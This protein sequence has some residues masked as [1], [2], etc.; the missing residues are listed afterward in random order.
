MMT[1]GSSR[2][3]FAFPRLSFA[4]RRKTMQI[5][6]PLWG[7]LR[8]KLPGCVREGDNFS[9][10]PVRIYT[11][12]E[13]HQKRDGEGVKRRTAVAAG[14]G[15]T[16][17][18]C[19][20]CEPESATLPILHAG[21]G[22]SISHCYAARCWIGGSRHPRT[23]D[24]KRYPFSFYYLPSSSAHRASDIRIMLALAPTRRRD[25]AG[26]RLG[27]KLG[28]TPASRIVID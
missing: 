21:V 28:D 20:I 2:L 9:V 18:G 3:S 22:P 13:P 16:A 10:A 27:R 1:L 7:T 11:H 6:T 25:P 4:A 12:R 24:F 17:E 8:C 19:V 14:C 5:P 15:G 23:L 26:R